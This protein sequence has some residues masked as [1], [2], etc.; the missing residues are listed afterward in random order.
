MAARSDAEPE[1]LSPEAWIWSLSGSPSDP[2]AAILKDVWIRTD[3][4]E[5][6]LLLTV[7]DPEPGNPLEHTAMIPADSPEDRRQLQASLA[8]QVGRPLADLAWIQVQ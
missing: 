4:D 1:M 8:L 7:S 3:G 5:E 6:S 2:Y